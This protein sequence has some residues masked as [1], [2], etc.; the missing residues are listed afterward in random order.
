MTMRIRFTFLL[1]LVTQLHPA[2]ADG[3]RLLDAA[4]GFPTSPRKLLDK[5][6][7]LHVDDLGGKCRGLM[8]QANAGVSI[9]T[10]VHHVH[11]LT[12]SPAPKPDYLFSAGMMKPI[13]ASFLKPDASCGDE[14]PATTGGVLL[15][16]NPWGLQG[17]AHLVDIEVNCGRGS[18]RLSAQPTYFVNPKV[19]DKT[20]E[21]PLDPTR[22]LQDFLAPYLDGRGTAL[23][24]IDARMTT[25]T[26]KRESSSPAFTEA[27]SNE[28]YLTIHAGYLATW[29]PAEQQMRVVYYR[30]HDDRYSKILS[31][32]QPT[33]TG[34]NV[35]DGIVARQVWVWGAEYAVE[36][37]Y[38]R[39]GKLV[40]RIEHPFS[41]YEAVNPPELTD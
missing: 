20:P 1:L 5:V 29:L 14:H 30:N 6:L 35:A 24:V 8:V 32:I 13:F 22:L 37:K 19:L 16:S 17:D 4:A 12:D 27:R 15:R 18:P 28:R 9:I 39:E 36:A 25:E 38:S 26:T 33:S 34:G 2:V 10:S 21:F 3:L 11:N 23:S 40:A 7:P 31:V 41:T